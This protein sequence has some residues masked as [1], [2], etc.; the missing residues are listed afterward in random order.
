MKYCITSFLETK[1]KKIEIKKGVPRILCKSITVT[2][3]GIITLSD[4]EIG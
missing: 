4:M 2:K 1:Q 3:F